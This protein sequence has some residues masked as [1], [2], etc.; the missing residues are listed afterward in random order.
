VLAAGGVL[1]LSAADGGFF[2]PSWRWGAAAFAAA[3]CVAVLLER[4]LVV[5]RAGR[6]FIA[7]VIAYLAVETALAFRFRHHVP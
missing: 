5:S 2:P 7:C 1:L 3:G 4:G 6:A